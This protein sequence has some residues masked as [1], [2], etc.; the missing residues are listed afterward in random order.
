M[1][2]A[3]FPPVD[4]IRVDVG[5]A[6]Y[7]ILQYVKGTDEETGLE[8]TFKLSIAADG[9]IRAVRPPESK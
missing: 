2:D 7:A 9:T 3:D 8:A 6:F 4:L 5:G 1:S